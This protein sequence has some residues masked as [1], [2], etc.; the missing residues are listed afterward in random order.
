[1][2]LDGA[3]PELLDRLQI[4]ADKDEIRDQ[5]YRYC[6]GVDHDDLELVVDCFHPHAIDDH[7]PFAR[8]VEDLV[9]LLRSPAP[10]GSLTYHL[11]G[12][13]LIEV[14][15]ARA[16]AESYSICYA[17]MA[18]D[19]GVVAPHFL[20]ARFVDWFEKRDGAWR[21]RKRTVVMD[22]SRRLESAPPWTH[23]AP[24][25]HAARDDSDPGTRARRAFR[26]GAFEG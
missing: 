17:Q 20:G 1:M 24:F 2:G 12:N 18:D 8:S 14:R 3:A 7:G 5:L 6:R 26:A 21:I 4:L 15:G 23:A 19:A 16:L 25:A 9:A 11:V 10:E 22:W 13:V